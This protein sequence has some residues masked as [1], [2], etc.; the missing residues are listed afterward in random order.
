M[1]AFD[2]QSDPDKTPEKIKK[3]FQHCLDEKKSI[4][5]M[6]Y[7]DEKQAWYLYRNVSD[8]QGEPLWLNLLEA[9][10]QDMPVHQRD[11]YAEP[12]RTKQWFSSKPYR[13]RTTG[14]PMITYST[15]MLDE[16]GN[17]F[18]VI[19]CDVSLRWI[20]EFITSIR[21]P[22]A[23]IEQIFMLAKDGTVLADKSWNMLFKNIFDY[24]KEQN[25]PA[26]DH[27]ARQM[28]DGES[29]EVDYRSPD[30]KRDGRII[31]MP[32]DDNDGDDSADW[33]LGIFVQKKV[34]RDN[35][36]RAG[37][38]QALIGLFGMILLISAFRLV[39]RGISR[40][41][42]LLHDAAL[43]IA[44]GNLDTEIPKLRQQDEVGS[45]ADSFEQM[46]H[47]LKSHI[48]SLAQATKLR[49]QIESELRIARQIQMSL[50]PK[51]R[52][53]TPFTDRFDLSAVMEPAKQ[54][55]GDF[56]DY[57]MI[58]EET[59]CIVIADVSGKGVPASLLMARNS[60]SFHGA[61]MNLRHPG[62]ALE[63]VNQEM[64]N[65]N[66]ANMFVTMFA[67]TVNISNGE[68]S[69]A[70]A[71]HNPPFLLRNGQKAEAFEFAGALPVGID[72]DSVY[73]EHTLKLD[74]GDLVFLYT[75]GVTEAIDSNSCLFGE[76]RTAETIDRSASKTCS[77]LLEQVRKSIND[78]V[79]ETPQSDDITM[80]AFRR[81]F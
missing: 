53:E 30:G 8:L 47:E 12:A 21:L 76:A 66:D 5:G 22:K 15:P 19:A 41:I 65:D 18:G 11:W 60:A 52:P 42:Q 46:Q 29:K 43:T 81:L 58:D 9:K 64:Y 13:G 59:L 78:F 55:G 40:P 57:F 77:E 24:A 39:A 54:V 33:S 4:F 14:V 67:M 75:D 71:G 20:N 51:R 56:Y 6:I 36:F 68:C 27:I 37:R 50:V 63:I 73:H 26:L 48:N 2:L 3:L 38:T 69:Y 32:I 70:N 10:Q 1:S 7:A 45:L 80:L 49:E 74:E 44:S 35:A 34:M 23:D 79:Q 28:L 72:S 31:F 62:P 25:D 16:D 17:F 61:M